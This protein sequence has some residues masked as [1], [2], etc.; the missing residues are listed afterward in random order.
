MTLTHQIIERTLEEFVEGKPFFNALD[1][2]LCNPAVVMEL[3]DTVVNKLGAYPYV[4]LSGKFGAYWHNFSGTRRSFILLDGNIRDTGEV[5]PMDDIAMRLKDKPFIFI[6]DS[7]YS[8]RTR[9]AIKVALEERGATLKH[10]F[11]AYDGSQHPLDPEVT[12]LYRYHPSE[13]IKDEEEKV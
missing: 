13:G 9:D 3:W 8:K 1:K 7:L 12:S 2:A 5:F 11:V 10:T 6:D 4:I